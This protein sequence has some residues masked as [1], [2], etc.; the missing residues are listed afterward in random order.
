M[1]RKERSVRVQIEG[2]RVKD[3]AL[4]KGHEKRKGRVVRLCKHNQ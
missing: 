4:R 2:N 1:K 3:V